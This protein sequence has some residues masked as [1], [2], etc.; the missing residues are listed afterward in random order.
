M[1]ACLLLC[2][3]DTTDPHNMRLAVEREPSTLLSGDLL[4]TALPAVALH[5]EQWDLIAE[6]ARDCLVLDR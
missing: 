4:F 1:F 2:T 3:Q 5:K 6:Y